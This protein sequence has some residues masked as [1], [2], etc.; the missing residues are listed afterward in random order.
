MSHAAFGLFPDFRS[1]AFVMR[2]PVSVIIIL[3][4]VEVFSGVAPGHLARQRLGAIRTL[5]RIRLNDLCAM[6]P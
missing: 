2:A 4:R 5:Q 3:I 6:N 1:S